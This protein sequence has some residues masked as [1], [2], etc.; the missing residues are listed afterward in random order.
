MY[1]F[2]K[3][4]VNKWNWRWK[5]KRTRRYHSEGLLASLGNLTD[6]CVSEAFRLLFEALLDYECVHWLQ[7]HPTSNKGTNSPV[8]FSHIVL[9]LEL[10]FH[11][12]HFVYPWGGAVV[13]GKPSFVELGVFSLCLRGFP[14]GSLPSSQSPK[15]T[16]VCVCVWGNCVWMVMHGWMDG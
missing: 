9:V 5:K 4:F 3:L 2:A 1:I 16:C 7:V 12:K 10:H 8:W 6:E 15:K 13:S 14:P 11:W